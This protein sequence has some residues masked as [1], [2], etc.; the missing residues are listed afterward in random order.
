MSW[1]AGQPVLVLG[2]QSFDFAGD[3]GKQIKFCKYQVITNDTPPRDGAGF[4]VQEA[5]SE[6]RVEPGWHVA[7]VTYTTGKDKRMLLDFQA[8]LGGLPEI[9]PPNGSKK[10]A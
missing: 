10:A 6:S 7:Q 1:N 8:V 2:V 3:D 9:A 5:R 4:V